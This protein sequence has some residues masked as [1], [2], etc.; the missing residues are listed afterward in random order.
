MSTIAYYYAGETNPVDVRPSVNVLAGVGFYAPDGRF[1]IP[2]RNIAAGDLGTGQDEG[3]FSLLKAN[4]A[5]LFAVGDTLTFSVGGVIAGADPLT[6]IEASPAGERRVIAKLMNGGAGGGGGLTVGQVNTLIA[7]AEMSRKIMKITGAEPNDTPPGPGDWAVPTAGDVATVER[8]TGTVVDRTETYT[9]NGAIWTLVTIQ[10]PSVG[11]GDAAGVFTNLAARPVVGTVTDGFTAYVQSNRITYQKQDGIYRQ[12][13]D[14]VTVSGTTDRDSLTEKP[15]NMRIFNTSSNIYEKWNGTAWVA[16]NVPDLADTPVAN[17]AALPAGRPDGYTVRVTTNLAEYRMINGVYQQVTF[18]RNVADIAA[19]NA[20][21]EVPT[22]YQVFVESDNT[23]WK[24]NGA[25]WV[26]ITGGGGGGGGATTLLGLTDVPDVYGTAGQSIR[27][28]T[29]ATGMEFFTPAAAQGVVE[30]LRGT[31]TAG[32]TYARFTVANNGTGTPDV[33]Y[34]PG[35]GAV[36]V[37]VT[38]GILLTADIFLRTGAE[39]AGGNSCNVTFTGPGF[40]ATSFT[41]FPSR[42]SVYLDPVTN[43]SVS[44]SQGHAHGPNGTGAFDVHRITGFAAGT[45]HRVV[46]NF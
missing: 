44:L 15:V 31:A 3:E 13:T 33:V 18:S 41:R 36:T 12:I 40:L 27:V 4:S 9:H 17:I 26:D 1:L 25:A 11:G 8:R 45:N 39:I 6:V 5:T 38:N 19:R 42:V 46:F 28:N 16:T 21:T 24:W 43:G 7:N 37:A 2:A 34:T 35:A 32:N 30:L 23:R 29:G 10:V 14:E 20:L 22:N